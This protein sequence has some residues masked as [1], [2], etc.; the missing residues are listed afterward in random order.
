MSI[1][2]NFI[3]EAKEKKVSVMSEEDIKKMLRTERVDSY[4][5]DLMAKRLGVDLKDIPKQI[6]ENVEIKLVNNY[7][8]ANFFQI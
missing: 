4:T 6:L 2:R 3:N 7:E 8:N 1:F 5:V